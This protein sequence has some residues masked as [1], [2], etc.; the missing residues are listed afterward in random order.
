VPENEPAGV[1]ALMAQAQQILVQAQRLIEFAAVHVIARLPIGNLKEL[2]GRTQLFPQHS[3]TGIGMAQFRR[4]RSLDTEQ[5]RT[6]GSVK[7][8]FLP[9]MFEI[10]GNSASW[11]SAF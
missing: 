9:P 11:S 4:G 10:V 1:V 3:R 6:E 8:E 2:R 5:D 7:S